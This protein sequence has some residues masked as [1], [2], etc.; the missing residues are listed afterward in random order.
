MNLLG[1]VPGIDPNKS[2]NVIYN[3]K[4]NVVSLK[5][6]VRNDIDNVYNI[7]KQAQSYVFFMM[8]KI[9]DLNHIN[10]DV[11]VVE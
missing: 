9:L 6:S 10:I 7:I 2:V 3:D 11:A 4:H 1:K 8:C 5:F